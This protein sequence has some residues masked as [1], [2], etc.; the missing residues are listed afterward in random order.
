MNQPGTNARNT[1]VL[2]VMTVTQ[3]KSFSEQLARAKIS[4]Y[5]PSIY[6]LTADEGDSHS[7]RR[8][9]EA[10]DCRRD[11]YHGSEPV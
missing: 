5:Y 10:P 11:K 1:N 6:L 7:P 3:Q 2:K 8:A 4:L 9:K